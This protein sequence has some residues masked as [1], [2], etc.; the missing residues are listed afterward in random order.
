MSGKTLEAYARDVGQFLGFLAEHLGGAP[1]LK[2]LAKLTP[3]DIRAFM[4]ARRADGFGN[5]SLMRVLAGARSFARYLERNGKGK[6]GGARRGARAQARQDPAQAAIRQR[7]QAHDRHRR[8]RRR[9]PRALG[10]GARRRRPGAALWRGP[11]HLRGA[12]PHAQTPGRCGR[13]PH[14]HRQ[15]QQDA[16][17]AA[18]AAGRQA[19][20]RLCRALPVRN[21]AGRTAVR[22]RAR[23][24]AVAAHRAT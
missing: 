10:A 15:G 19:D 14:R 2:Q 12:R 8:A 5:R 24:A 13:R 17:G 7:R 18:V 22:R 9:N 16:H 3:A 4:A 20:R 21:R 11:A 1:T 23:R 6:V